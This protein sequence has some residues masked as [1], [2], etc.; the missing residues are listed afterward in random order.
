M[1]GPT[2]AIIEVF[3]KSGK[4]HDHK[5]DHKHDKDHKHDHKKI[6]VRMPTHRTFICYNP[7]DVNT[8]GDGKKRDLKKGHLVSFDIVKKD[9]GYWAQN[10]DFEKRIKKDHIDPR[11]GYPNLYVRSVFAGFLVLFAVS[12]ISLKGTSLAFVSEQFENPKFLP[13]AAFVISKMLYVIFIG[14]VTGYLAGARTAKRGFFTGLWL[15]LIVGL[16]HC[17][18]LGLLEPGTSFIVWIVEL[19]RH[20]LEFALVAA[21]VGAILGSPGELV[22][23]D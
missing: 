11:H 18:N 15:G 10:I 23:K 8:D 19:L 1:N 21:V 2:P 12:F 20:I 6:P 9:G 16:I 5:H 22:I 7:K 4:R 13:I 3:D 14:L 17:L